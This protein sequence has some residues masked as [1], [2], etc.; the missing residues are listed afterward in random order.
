MQN[1]KQEVE[2]EKMPPKLKDWLYKRITYLEQ[3]I[4]KMLEVLKFKI[5]QDLENQ[6]MEAGNQVLDEVKKY[7]Q[8][9]GKQFMLES[10]Q[11]NRD[12]TLGQ[13]IY[14]K[15]GTVVNGNNNVAQ[16]LQMKRSQVGLSFYKSGVGGLNLRASKQGNNMLMS[17]I[18]NMMRMSR[19]NQG[20]GGV[21]GIIPK[22]QDRTSLAQ[23]AFSKIGNLP[24][25]DTPRNKNIQ[26]LDFASQVLSPGGGM[27][28][29][30]Q[31][32]M[33]GQTMYTLDAI[34]KQALV[35]QD[36]VIDVD[37]AKIDNARKLFEH[38][39]QEQQFLDLLQQERVGRILRLSK[40]PRRVNVEENLTRI[41]GFFVIQIHL[42]F[43]LPSV[44]H[45]NTL[46][47]YWEQCLLQLQKS[48]EQIV[49]DYDYQPITQTKKEIV[50]FI[51]AIRDLGLAQ[52]LSFL[53]T[54][55]KLHDVFID[56]L[57]LALEKKIEEILE[58]ENY[59]PIRITN[60]E[61]LFKYA[62]KY[63]IDLSKYFG[64]NQNM[65]ISYPVFLPY[66][67]SVVK[68]NDLLQSFIEENFQYWQF[69][70]ADKA[71][72]TLAYSSCDRI[73]SR[74]IELI[75][76]H[77]FHKNKFTILQRAQFCSNLEYILKSFGFF[78]KIVFQLSNQG[79]YNF[80]KDIYGF[81]FT[82]ENMM[83]HFK[84]KCEES[85]FTE[86][87]QK[88]SDF[89]SILEGLQWRPK[90]PDNTHHEFVEDLVMF[91]RSTIVNLDQQ[92]KELAKQCYLTT[93]KHLS[94]RVT[95]VLANSK[96][97]SQINQA[98]ILNLYQDYQYLMKFAKEQ[99]VDNQQMFE[100]GMGELQQM[101]SLFLESNPEE[102]VCKDQFKKTCANS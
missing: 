27:T 14:N 4:F 85:I 44:F 90:K 33:R 30:D 48:L 64:M 7:L 17:S 8:V 59:E 79:A 68:L 77:F 25:Y 3:R 92:N 99:M 97:I 55:I 81:Q 101:I 20:A 50:N 45:P 73:L 66:S 95:E 69:L 36:I 54:L 57:L 96:T 84:I 37:F 35:A 82:S 47:Q 86:L 24:K 43:N 93:F 26:G 80:N 40:L 9:L 31:T 74:T 76:E 15:N 83:N 49:M 71:D 21:G 18:N 63:E 91:L 62:D 13:T 23:I 6:E 38:I 19:Y 10:D 1:L 67:L 98:G 61:E 11:D 34:Q 28:E 29:R 60:S 58:Y 87:R 52:D 51:L 53:N 70:L 22:F 94:S 32:Q 41:I 39:E 102:E 72:F 46:Q 2:D 75:S 5:L 88:I 12:L 89:L 42:T 65:N 56:K 100:I 16:Y 78:K